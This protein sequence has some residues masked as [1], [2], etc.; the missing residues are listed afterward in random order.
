M[1]YFAFAQYDNIFFGLLR[2]CLWQGLA[3]TKYFTHPLNPP[4][5]GRGK[6][7]R[8]CVRRISH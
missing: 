1:R 2:P 5:Q 4:P 7:L 6:F 8:F 3:M